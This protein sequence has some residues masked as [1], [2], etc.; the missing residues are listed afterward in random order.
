MACTGSQGRIGFQDGQSGFLRPF[1]ASC[2]SSQEPRVHRFEMSSLNLTAGQMALLDN[3]IATRG[4]ASGNNNRRGSVTRRLN[5]ETG[6]WEPVGDRRE[7]GTPRI[8]AAADV[9]AT[10]QR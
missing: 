9:V 5:T 7:P 10:P 1:N 3:L 2:D 4:A 8:R 6:R